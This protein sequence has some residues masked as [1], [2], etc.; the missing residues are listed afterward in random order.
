MTKSSV[1]FSSTEKV[2]HLRV[3]CPESQ[4]NLLTG[5]RPSR[6]SRSD[7]SESRDERLRTEIRLKETECLGTWFTF[8]RLWM[9]FNLEK[10]D[11]AGLDLRVI[12]TLDGRFYSILYHNGLR[13]ALYSVVGR[14]DFM[15]G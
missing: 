13:N 10:I 15:D 2:V 5:V 9:V 12:R 1:V 6:G 8:L 14:L 7:V 11:G 4:L 3:L